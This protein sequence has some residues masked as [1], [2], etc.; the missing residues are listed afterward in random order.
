MF[1]HKAIIIII[2][3]IHFSSIIYNKCFYLITIMVNY[4]FE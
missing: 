1:G 4:E 2:M 3:I